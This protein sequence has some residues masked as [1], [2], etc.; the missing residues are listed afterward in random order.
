MI[1]GCQNPRRPASAAVSRARGSNLTS[2]GFANALKMR[3]GKRTANERPDYP[4]V[5]GSADLGEGAR[6]GRIAESSGPVIIVVSS[7]IS[8]RMVNSR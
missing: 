1:K 2:G 7:A 8:T 6:A 5:T 4:L 3:R